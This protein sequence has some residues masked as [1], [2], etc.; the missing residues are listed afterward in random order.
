VAAVVVLAVLSLPALYVLAFR[1]VLRRLALRYPARRP[2]EAALVV[3]GTLL[4]TSIIT[5]SLIVGDTIDRSISASA[6]EQLGPIDELVTVSGL[7]EGRALAERFEG[8]TAPGLDGTLVFVTVPVAV[9]GGANQPRAQLL[10]LDAE[11]AATF[12]GDSSITG[13]EG[14]NP[15]AGHAVVT[16]D[17]ARRARLEV[18]DVALAYLYGTAVPFEVDRIVPRTGVAGFWPIDGRQQSY[19]LIVAPGTVERV[20]DAV[21]EGAA[22]AE[23]P[24]VRIAFS[25]DGGV[26]GGVE[27]TDAVVPAVEAVLGGSDAVVRPVKRDLLTAATEA[28]ESLTQLYFTM[29]MFAVAAG[30][31]LVVNIFVMLADERRSELGMLRAIGLRRLPL[32]G[33]FTAEG[34]LYSLVAGAIGA[35]L[36]IAFGWVIAW[37]AED[38]LQSS[39]DQRSLSLT[40]SFEWSTVLTGLVAG[41]A[42]SLATIV[43][44][45]VR[46]SRG[47]VIAAIRDL[48][49]SQVRTVGGRWQ[50]VGA[51]LV[52]LGAAWTAVG[53]TG[54]DAYGV[55]IGPIL[56]LVGVGALLARTTDVRR[57][58]VGVS[59]AVLVWGTAFIPVL[60]ALD[61]DV[62][63]PVFLVQGLSMAAAGVALVTIYQGV[64]G[65]WVS[66]VAG[67]PLPVRLGM[68]YPIARRWRT[69]MTLGMFAVVILTLV[70]LSVISFMFRSQVDDI[71]A[72]MSGGFGVV[73]V[74]N[75]T[76]P[77][78]EEALA[79]LPGTGR[80]A[81][82]AYG[83]ADFELDGQEARS[84]PVTGFGSELVAAPP[85]L[86]DRGPY[87]TDEAAWE[88]V[89]ADPDLI[90]VDEFFLSTGGGPP[91]G[92]PDPGDRFAI[93]D[94][95]TGSSRTV[96]VAA[97]A[98]ND[99]LFNGAFY[100]IG[101][102]EELT[103]GR[104][105]ASRFYV[106][107]EGDPTEVAAAIR[108]EFV[109]NG[110]DAEA[111]TDT[112][113][114]ALV[115]QTGFFTLMQQFVG[116]GLLVGIA[117]IGV[118][119]V[120][121]VRERRRIV[122]VM[123]SLGFPARSVGA[124]FLV[125]AAFVAFEGVVLGV[126]VAL[127]G[128]YGLVLS[129]ATFAEGMTWGVPWTEVL[130]ISLLALVASSV[131]A[132]WPARRA[133]RIR[134]AEALRITD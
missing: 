41:F 45:S 27:A 13:I 12:G 71:A 66:R 40:F 24:E 108:T 114:G 31:L 101:G 7:D 38:I 115:Q 103:A 83:L 117:G 55:T 39:S 26:E 79:A 128:S 105:V 59:V 51:W 8:F 25:N 52:L 4:G 93:R 21:G 106:E 130:G 99:F 54:G 5:G 133:S 36:G 98:E 119:M 1:P 34:W 77:L 60:G 131:A 32:V 20:L 17:L 9:S 57:A 18:G 112:I 16:E 74:S 43:A 70:Y 22:T 113:D 81:P 67:S 91:T 3:L 104:A 61:I 30:V 100:G 58:T 82:L 121:A 75:P 11:E 56:V 69:A 2:V 42:I 85:V 48:P 102:L 125:E 110:A 127:V 92:T 116:V 134:P 86:Q 47:N 63:I 129:G 29:G 90:I 111:V 6:Y 118:I 78:P 132:L 126:A 33:A 76:D 62:S 84:W 107:P 44:T 46:T 15:P 10:E 64:I 49:A 35:L 23:P 72:D 88:A 94:P 65:R 14:P 122:G 28:A 50:W 53:W 87:P 89:L 97:L 96:E 68:A 80:I 19:N 37:R 109:A 95:V 73:V 124:A 120:R 123:R